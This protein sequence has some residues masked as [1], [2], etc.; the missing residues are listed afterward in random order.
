M[1]KVSINRFDGGKAQDLRSTASNQ[2]Y[3]ASHFNIRL[4]PHRLIPLAD[5]EADDT[6]VTGNNLRTFVRQEYTAGTKNIFALGNKSSTSYLKIFEKSPADDITGTW[7]AS[8]NAEGTGGSVIYN[9]LIAFANNLYALYV[10]GSDVKLA[11]YVRSTTTFTEAK[12]TITNGVS[13]YTGTV[14]P[15]PHIHSKDGIMYMGAYNKLAKIDSALTFSDISAASSIL[16]PSSYL[17]TSLAE[18]GNYLAIAAKDVNY[19][20]NS[21]VFL[22]DRDTSLTTFS[23]VIDWGDGAL[24]V[25][26]NIDGYLVGIS[27]VGS[28]SYRK[29]PRIVIKVW[30]QG[31]P[32][33]VKEITGLSLTVNSLS[34][35][36]E[37]SNNELYFS[38]NLDSGYQIYAIGRNSL[39]EWYIT[40]SVDPNNGTAVTSIGGF[41]VL[42]DIF[43]VQY[44]SAGAINRTNDSNSFTCPSTWETTIN[45][46]MPEGDK[47]KMKQLVSIRVTYEPLGSLGQVVAKYKVDGGS[48]TTIYTDSTDNSVVLETGVDA[49]GSQFTSGRE[50]QFQVISTGGAEITGIE[51]RYEVL[52]T[53]L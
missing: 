10:S 1:T 42:G 12:G 15:R 31:Q 18:Y 9:S 46:N 35:V 44:D 2:F 51:Y 28:T 45:Q 34:N 11:Q 20:G 24:N 7:S 6:G 21:K 4:K 47:G 22:W 38:A 41:S 52:E 5:M 48:Y 3:R 25:L 50:Y 32:V 37:K 17:I 8:N 16:L 49:N 23:E 29:E 27:E 43:Y 36:K 40:E 14:Y 33:V 53:L 39:G 19:I 13:S 30:N 26:S